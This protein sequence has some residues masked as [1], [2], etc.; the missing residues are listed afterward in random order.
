[1]ETINYKGFEIEIIQDQN[2]QNP[3]E[4]WDCNLPLMY[5]SGDGNNDYSKGDIANFLAYALTDNQIIYHQKKLAEIFDID[6]DY[7]V[8]QE[9]S[10]D[11]KISDIRSEIEDNTNL[12]RFVYLAEIAKIPH[13]CTSS[14]GYSQ[15]DYAELFVCQTDKFLKESGCKE[16]TPEML[17]GA[18]DLWGNWAW[19]NVYGFNVEETGDSCWGFYG[20]DHE[21]SGLL[22]MAR[23]EIDY[24]IKSKKEARYNRLKDLIKNKVPYY[25]RSTE[26]F[27]H[28]FSL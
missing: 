27:N 25:I 28:K 26:L 22:E 7:F 10:K 23:P 5:V 16:V 8:E 2:A 19:G 3:F 12:A 15:G 24:Y 20:D 4:E 1:M 18:V 11:D 14:R 6:L 17:Q 13:L 21:K 9:F